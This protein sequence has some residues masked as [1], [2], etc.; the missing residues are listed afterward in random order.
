MRVT[1][2][3][4]RSDSRRRSVPA[5]ILLLALSVLLS[6]CAVDRL[7]E[8]DVV[9]DLLQLDQQDAA[10]SMFETIDD[11]ASQGVVYDDATAAGVGEETQDNG[12]VWNTDTAGVP[13][14]TGTSA[15]VQ[16]EDILSGMEQMEPV[17]GKRSREE[18]EREDEENR[19]ALGLTDARIAELMRENE[20]NY[21]FRH[22]DDAG[23]R[24]YAEVYH[25]IK[26]RGEK[27][28]IS[29]LDDDKVDQ[30]FQ[31][32]MA[33]HPEIFYADGYTYTR[34]TIDDEL[35]KLGFTARYVY[36]QAETDR[37]AAAIEKVVDRIVA[38]A[39]KSTD[40]YDLAKYVYDYI[41]A[42]TEYEIGADDNQNICSV[43]LSGKSV[44][45]G[46]AKAT[47]LLLNR[48]GVETTLV[49]GTVSAGDRM[50][51]R[52]AWNLANVNGRNY[53]LDTTWGDSSFQQAA[54]E[55]TLLQRTNYDYLLDTTADLADTHVLDDLVEMPVCKNLEDNY[56]V[57]DGAYFTGVDEEQ[58]RALFD[59]G[60]REKR[61]YVTVKCADE[62]A[63]R[64]LTDHLVTKRKLFDYLK[65][66]GDSASFASS[67]TQR[68]MTFSL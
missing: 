39:P 38:G 47:Q 27:I 37:R 41:L 18:I 62:T 23:K 4:N 9:Y 6:G 13:E 54:A 15:S 63:Y 31:Y 30:A 16:E 68:T 65:N 50:N 5:G 14:Q 35:F 67:D 29:S 45:Q 8:L 64:S 28:R 19:Q 3:K 11:P 20:G 56:Y 24:L 32:V 10:Q 59:K 25:I 21:Y 61:S 33:D 2:Q 40:Q 58:L 26:E 12:A 7:K 42:H 49:T 22:L 57:R 52:H 34:Y 36:D 43:F 66:P 17:S 44:C 46:Y 1:R 48:L 53:Y 60:Y 55:E 51:S